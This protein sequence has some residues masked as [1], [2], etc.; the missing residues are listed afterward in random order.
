[1]GKVASQLSELPATSPEDSLGTCP[2]A[3]KE[4][5]QSPVIL[6]SFSFVQNMV[7]VVSLLVQIFLWWVALL[8]D[9]QI[10]TT[11][12]SRTLEMWGVLCLPAWNREYVLQLSSK[13]F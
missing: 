2:G 4:N 3:S 12:R 9:W 1:M 13:D 10:E 7:V 5:G 11:L 6:R 8:W